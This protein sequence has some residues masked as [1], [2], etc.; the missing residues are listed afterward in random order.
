MN[1]CNTCRFWQQDRERKNG[2]GTCFLPD[3]N[4]F[5]YEYSVQ[6]DSGLSI[7]VVTAPSFGC[8]LHQ[9]GIHWTRK[10]Q[11]E[12]NEQDED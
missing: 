2:E 1:T 10:P 5:R 6:D 3:W 12:D 7:E 11:E 8:I 9:D 4:T